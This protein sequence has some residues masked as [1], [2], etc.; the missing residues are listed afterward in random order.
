MAVGVSALLL[1]F[2]FV[3]FVVSQGL[4]PKFGGAPVSPLYLPALGLLA[5]YLS[6]WDYV[7]SR[8]LLG[9][10]RYGDKKYFAVKALRL[11][12]L[13]F[14]AA[15]ASLHLTYALTSSWLA[16]LLS[17]LAL[18]LPRLIPALEDLSAFLLSVWALDEVW[19]YAFSNFLASSSIALT[20]LAAGSLGGRAPKPRGRVKSS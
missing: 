18:K 8:V 6:S 3:N 13:L 5:V 7:F 16:G 19:K 20:A 4:D 9:A 1:Q 2:R 11:M 14:S 12:L 10:A 15:A 17:S